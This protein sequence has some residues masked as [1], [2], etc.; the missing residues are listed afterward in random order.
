L[1]LSHGTRLGV[2]EVTA[3]IGEGGMG[4]VYR[5]TDTKL[6]RQVAIKILP[7]SLAA[8]HD[9]LARFQREAEVLALLN[10]SNIA[11]IYGVEESG[12]FTALVMELVEGE[13]L[14]QRISRGAIPLD[15]AWPIARQIAD[16]LEAAHE[17][18]IIHRD[19]KP[20]NI[21]VR[22]DGTV[23]VLDYGLAKAVD[24]GA[25][26]A[27]L[28]NSPTLTA[29]ATRMGVLLGTAAYM[30]PEQAR[31][32]AVDKRADIWAFGSVLYEMVT[33]RVAFAAD[34]VSDTIVAVLSREPDW[35]ALPGTI[36]PIVV[37]VLKRC[38]Q[39]DQSLRMRDIADARFQ[40]EEGLI[41]ALP[42]Q[43]AS[44]ARTREGYAG[45]V[46]AAL[47]A[48]GAAI[49]ISGGRRAAGDAPEMRLQI[50]TP[51]ADDSFS[52]AISPDGRSVVAQGRAEGEFKLWLRPLESEVGR[53][54][55]G[56]EDATF[57][58]WS[59]DSR[60]VGFFAGGTLKRIDLAGGFVRTLASAPNPRRG[61]WNSEGTIIFGASVGPLY[62][63][64]AD[65]G[66]V[67]EA[68]NL[69]PG[70]AG[71]RWP[72]FLPD[73]RR[74][75]LFA[76]GA[77]NVRGVYLGSLADKE[78][79]RVLETDSA[80]AFMSP[81]YLVLAR[82]GALWAQ[83]LTADLTRPDGE[84]LPLASRVLIHPTHNGFAAL[85]SSSVGSVAYRA[86]AENR[87]LVW[88]DRAGRQVGDL[89]PPDDAQ[90]FLSQMSSDGRTVA[91]RRT[92]SG[93][94]DVWL[95]DTTRGVP[96][97]LT[98][99]PAIEGEPIFS[100]DGKRVVY[101]SDRKVNI[102]DMYERAADGS[103][104]ETLLFESGEN[105]H[106]LDWS[107]DGR[108]ILYQSDSPKT[109]ADLW[110]LPLVGD[111]KQVAVAQTPFD[112]V[113]GR[114]SPDGRW[115]AYVSNEGGRSEI[116]VQPFPDPGSKS[117]VSV[118]GG[119]TP[120]WRRDGRELFYIAPDSRLMAVSI[121]P[122]ES[123]LGAA[124]PFA[125]FTLPKAVGYEPARDGQRVLV[126]AIVSD[127]SPITII[128]NWKPPGR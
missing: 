61:A 97:R 25:S 59:P 13:D 16:A 58:F 93:N 80:F 89:G 35:R 105:K 122:R 55:M 43:P 70:Q 127:A 100:P 53:P 66:A 54:L 120:R 20:A 65:G 1:A 5:A 81:A 73:G 24:P 117:Q 32:R 96:R 8:D 75:L 72:Q 47:V 77:A 48:I 119:T 87:Q 68:T 108:Y 67:T 63:V 39:K 40:I 52:F 106:P 128:L 45:W 111:R 2:Y 15:E 36:P 83:R 71:H 18:G 44:R 124:A 38:L 31:G 60:S 51:P 118:G 33:G 102:W 27:D 12:G 9:R 94:T 99:D 10:H 34:T 78:V 109:D 56:T 69:L 19:L 103:G 23:K 28:A 90:P 92:V 42:D 116:Y 6:K 46:V 85:F 76:M 57:P 4:Q 21:K 3:Q 37:S 11:A 123:A 26:A 91:V 101:V 14:S 41:V 84:L 125:L 88:L 50:A 30:S 29:R 49:A 98:F 126:N 110:A 22:P 112:E 62:K 115:V 114:F 104:G 17:Q 82:Q 107:S 113:D 64:P 121:T 7:P 95:I 79:R 74:F 86:S